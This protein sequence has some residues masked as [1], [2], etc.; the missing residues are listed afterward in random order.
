MVKPGEVLWRPADDARDT[1]ALGRFLSRAESVTGLQF[2][3]YEAAWRWSV[4]DLDTFWQLVWEQ[5]GV[6]AHRQPTAVLGRREMPFA[7]WFPG[8]TLNYAEH[9]LRDRSSAVRVKARSQ[10]RA[11]QDL[12]GAELAALVGR[13]QQGLRLLGVSRGDRVIG[14][15]PNIPEALVTYLAVAGLGAIWCSVPIEMG[16]RSVL[17][18]VAQLDP[19]VLVCVDGYRW[20]ERIVHRRDQAAEICDQLP[21]VRVVEVPYLDAHAEPPAEAIAW[22][23]FTATQLPPTFEELPFDHPLVV[24]FSSGTTGL[25]KAIVHG[26]GGLLLEHAKALS[27]QMDVGPGDVGFWYTTTGWMVWNILVSGLVVGATI[28][29]FDGDPAWPDLGGQW[30]VAAE[31]KATLFGTSAGYLAACARSDLRPG[32]SYDLAALRELTSSGSPL[33]ATASEWVYDAVKSDVLLAPT[34]GGTDVCSGFVGGSSLTSVY[35]GEMSCRP[36][37]VATESFDEAGKPLSGRP[38]ELVVTLPMPSMPVAFWNDPDGSRYRAAYFDTYPGVWRHGDWIIHTERDTWVITGRSDATLNRGGVRL[39]TAEFYSVLDALPEVADSVVVHLEDDA[40]HGSLIALIVAAS[41]TDGDDDSLRS[42]ITAAIRGQLS[43]RHVPDAIVFVN[44]LPRNNNGKRLEVP[45]KRAAQGVA[46]DQA[47]DL[48]ALDDP[49]GF[50]KAVAAIA[51]AVAA[52]SSEP[53]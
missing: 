40:G 42:A 15:L 30:A 41:P 25:P 24:L 36:L 38:G 51:V 4:S 37:G 21:G 35:A 16:P 3:N 22:A 9:A 18:R 49:A 8:A 14:Y 19:K 46:I 50:V 32:A 17:D 11:S 26:H 53:G 44:A 48:S 43:P 29:L 7:Q 2:A 45:L 28:V 12:S 52:L 20:G 39:G 5:A 47:V 31:T 33:S 27:L 34:S 10:T 1:S 23:A 6:I 13:V